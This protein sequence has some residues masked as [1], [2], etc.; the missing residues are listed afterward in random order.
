[1]VLPEPVGPDYGSDLA[2]P[3]AQVDLLEHGPARL[4]GKA[5]AAEANLR[6]ELLELAR[7][8][9]VLDVGLDVQHLEGAIQTHGDV[10][11]LG[12]QAE[13]FLDA[14]RRVARECLCPIEEA[15]APGGD[16][17][18]SQETRCVDGGVR[19]REPG[20][21]GGNREQGSTGNE[22]HEHAEHAVQPARVKRALEGVH[23]VG[24]EAALLGPLRAV[25]LDHFH[26]DQG[27]LDA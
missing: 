1:M 2:P 26:S 14:L 15:Q 8:L 22:E 24:L 21:P 17:D 18:G 5:H 4:V 25:R 23:R 11:N 6:G 3:R 20:R 12:P 13:E 7:I 27:L 10:L 16:A 19:L 9:R